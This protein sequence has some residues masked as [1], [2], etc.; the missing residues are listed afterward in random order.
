MLAWQCACMMNK[1]RTPDE[2]DP[3]H[4]LGELQADLPDV[5]LII[6]GALEAQQLA[7]AAALLLLSLG[8]DDNIA[9]MLGAC[10]SAWCAC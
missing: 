8:L 9:G 5:G 6:R 4:R 2:W 1:L 7:S 10:K 3:C